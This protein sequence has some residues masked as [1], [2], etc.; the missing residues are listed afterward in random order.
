MLWSS[1]VPFGSSGG[2]Q[3]LQPRRILKSLQLPPV[4]YLG[5]DMATPDA[6]VFKRSRSPS[7]ALGSAIFRSNGSLSSRDADSH[8]F[9]YLTGHTRTLGLAG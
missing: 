5:D 3:K 1:V 6:V 8:P 2:G 4:H 9:E 7:N